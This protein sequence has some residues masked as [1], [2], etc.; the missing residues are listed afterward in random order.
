MLDM[1]TI[2]VDS[3]SVHYSHKRFTREPPYHGEMTSDVF[4]F[5][6]FISEAEGI[7][8]LYYDCKF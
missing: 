5:D 1:N 7:L 3:L 4:L 6:H 8:G 2:I